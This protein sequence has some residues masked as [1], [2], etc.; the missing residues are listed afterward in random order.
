MQPTLALRSVIRK[1]GLWMVA[2]S[3]IG[4][5]VGAVL[6]AIG[7]VTGFMMCIAVPLLLAA[8]F[9]GLWGLALIAYPDFR[10]MHLGDGARRDQALA[11]IDGELRDPTT[12]YQATKRGYVCV[13]PSWLVI[14]ADD[15]LVVEP[16]RDVLLA[17]KKTTTRRFSS[18]EEIVLRS[19]SKDYK[20][21]TEPAEN[22]WIM[23]VLA[24]A[25]PWAH[26]GYR[27]DLASM[28]KRVLAQQVDQ[29]MQAPS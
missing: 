25:A 12:S 23:N 10:L 8:P 14:H 22:D 27:P 15:E 3:M 28:D 13:T 6:F 2:L 16:R 17:Y 19:R 24:R 1:Q 7:L 4:M 29:R 5:I 18:T 11:H 21:L 26:L 9:A 20:V